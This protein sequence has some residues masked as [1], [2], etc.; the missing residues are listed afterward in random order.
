MSISS[1]YRLSTCRFIVSLNLRESFFKM[2]AVPEDA[3]AKIL[4][5]IKP[6]DSFHV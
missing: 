2:E 6:S 1:L 5:K 3:G 4:L